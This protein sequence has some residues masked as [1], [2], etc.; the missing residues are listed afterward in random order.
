MTGGAIALGMAADAALEALP[1]RLAMSETESPE[2]VVVAGAAEP[3]LCGQPRLL[4]AALAE[5]RG[6]VAIAAIR[7]A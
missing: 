7:L 6:I 2:R 1:G 4:M 5:L 3:P